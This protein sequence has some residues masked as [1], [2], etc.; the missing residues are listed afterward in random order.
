M[1]GTQRLCALA[2]DEVG[3]VE[4]WLW[5]EGCDENCINVVQSRDV[6]LQFGFAGA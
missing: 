1:P 2:A 5:L 3:T 4:Y 6:A